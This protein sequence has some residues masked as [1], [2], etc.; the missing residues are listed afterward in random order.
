MTL[1]M[2][3]DARPDPATDARHMARAIELAGRG[4]GRAHPNPLVGAV[5]TNAAG[6]V[7]AEGWH[8]EFGGAHAEAAALARA[9]TAARGGTLYVTLEPCTHHGKTPPCV[10]A[11]L[12]SG[13][14]RVVIA[15]PDPDPVAAGGAAWLRASGIDVAVGVGAREAADR[16]APFL[17]WHRAGRPYVA[18]KLAMSLDARIGARVD[19]TTAVTG[20]PARDEVHRLR[21][22]FDAILVGG[23]T[24]QVDDPL[25]TVRGDIEPRRPPIRVVLDSGARLGADARI[26]SDTAVAPTWLF[27]APDAT[28]NLAALAAR[29][30]R[31]GR[32]RRAASGGLELDDVVKTL[33]AADVRSVLC[34]GGGRLSSSLLSADLVD[35]LYLFVAPKLYGAAAPAAFPSPVGDAVGTKWRVV[36]TSAIGDDVLIELARS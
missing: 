31:I 3:V 10:D 16:N 18:L 36:R 2:H 9:G 17:H 25:L 7:V 5:V 33:A 27:A 6:Q 35:R 4:W 26:A 19:A 22:G 14:A 13:V 20:G 8:A 23:R 12:R 21:A 28:G 29:G 1:A 34:E 24:A 30:V 11:V 32:A 15:V